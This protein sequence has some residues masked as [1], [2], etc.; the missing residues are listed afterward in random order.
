M[1][2]GIMG[3]TFDPIH[4]GHLFLAHE[5]LQVF[6]LDRVIFIP[7]GLGPHKKR[8]NT[9]DK[10][11]RFDMVAAAVKHEPKFEVSSLEI[12][13][14][15]YSYAIDTLESLKTLYPSDEFFFITG[16]DSFL[17]IES[18]KDYDLLLSKMAFVAAYRPEAHYA[19]Q[20]LMLKLETLVSRLS[21]T[22]G[23]N[24][25]ILQL[26]GLDVSSTVIRERIANHQQ[27]NYLVP[28]GVLEIIKE[29]GLYEV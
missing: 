29:R 10:H 20:E 1:K 9:A 5:A 7:S 22:Y 14:E 15:G 18:W 16:A 17:T 28:E 23:A 25:K 12:D 2:T 19:Q 3:G 4:I 11:H 24:I 26:I 6:G 27:V 8:Q 21:E 13:R